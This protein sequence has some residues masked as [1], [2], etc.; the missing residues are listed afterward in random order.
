MFSLKAN[1]APTRPAYTM[2][3]TT[4][5]NSRRRSSTI[6]RTPNPLRPSSTKGAPKTAVTTSG[7]SAPAI[8]IAIW[9]PVLRNRAPAG[10]HTAPQANARTSSHAGSTS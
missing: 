3:S 8:R 1:P 6:S 7:S 5:S 9:I 2:P 4:P 10:A